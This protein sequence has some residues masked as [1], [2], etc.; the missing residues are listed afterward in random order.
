MPLPDEIGRWISASDDRSGACRLGYC[1]LGSRERGG[2]NDDNRRAI[3]LGVC[4]FVAGAAHG[5][6]VRDPAS[7]AAYILRLSNRANTHSVPT[8]G[9]VFITGS[10]PNLV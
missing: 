10:M 1:G 6:G 7:N 9:T 4:L 5:P 2:K 8:R 3:Q